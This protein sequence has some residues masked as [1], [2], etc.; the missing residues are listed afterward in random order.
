MD[1]RALKL[2][3]RFALPPNS[4]GYCGKNT[5]PEKFK[6]CAVSGICDGVEEEIGKFIVLCP[7]IKTI[8]SITGLPLFSHKVMEAYWLGNDELKRARPKHYKL[9]LKNFKKQGVPEWLVKELVEKEPKK[10]IPT[11]LF[12][13]LHVGVG[14]ASGSVPFSLESIKNCMIRWGK[15]KKIKGTKME[16]DLSSIKPFSPRHSEVHEPKNLVPYELTIEMKTLTFS[17]KFLGEIK[18]GDAVAV[19]WGQVV[20][21]LTEQETKKLAYWTNAVLKSLP[22]P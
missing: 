8:A 10:F 3:S 4:L 20:K 7:Y 1:I 12:Q 21:I 16:I 22:K 15:V 5:A 2:T 14:R 18:V 19:H 13:V 6:K 11:H 9:L 17:R